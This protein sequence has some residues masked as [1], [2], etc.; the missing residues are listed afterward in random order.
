MKT[1]R[2]VLGSASRFAR[3]SAGIAPTFVGLLAFACWAG[4]GA[5]GDKKNDIV[6]TG[7]DAPTVGGTPTSSSGNTAASGR[8]VP[9]TCTGPACDLASND[10]SSL[11]APPGCGDGVLAN[12]EACD[13]GNT[14]SGDGCAANCLATEPG[15]SCATPG[16]LCKP[17]ARCGDGVVAPTEPCDD[18]NNVD[19]DGCSQ[20]CRIEL[21]KKCEGSPSVCTDAVC[22]NKLPEGAEACDDGNTTPFDGCS[23]QCLKEPTCTSAGCTSEC[24]DG[25]VINEDC[26]DG[27]LID[28]DGCSSDCKVENGFT[29]STGVTCGPEDQIDGKCVLRVAAIFRDFADSQATGGQ[30]NPNFGHNDKCTALTQGALA[31]KLDAN[32]R[33]VLSNNA[34]AVSAACLTTQADFGNWYTD[35]AQN[36]PLVGELVLFDNGNGGYTNRYD[37]QTGAQWQYVDPATEKDPSSTAPPCQASCQNEVQNNQAPFGTGQPLR[38][39]DTCRTYNDQIQQLNNGQIQQL[40]NQLNQAMNANPPDQAT[41]DTVTP[42]LAAAQAQLA[43]LQ[44]QAADCQ[45]TCQTSVDTAVAACLATCKPC[46][47]DPNQNC[48]GGV[49]KYQDG[50]PL[51]FPVDSIKGFTANSVAATIPEQYGYKGFPLESKVLPGAPNHNFNFTTEVE[52][53][54]KYDATTNAKLTFLGDDD[55][56]VFINGNLAVDL[57]GIHVPSTGTVTINAAAGTV[58]STA[59]D[60]RVTGNMTAP[61]INTQSTTAA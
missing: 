21:G 48:V 58:N 16:Q 56:W 37:S 23:N 53:W 39:A 42:M 14:E 31:A 10:S 44:T 36:V 27:N 51:F 40:T 41:I 9:S 8:F 49:T 4:C 7:N 19:G 50:T 43:D 54:F 38:C 11:P 25:L 57:G 1:R 22:G 24:G 34:A 17:I 15:F 13:D 18:G 3:P 33:P 5:Q 46:S 60:G 20:H 52:Y 30:T 47:F 29:C 6:T 2:A 45:T 32:G 61:P 35:N 26:D 12:D 28:G 59:Q 55:L